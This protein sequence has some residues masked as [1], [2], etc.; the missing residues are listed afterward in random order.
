MDIMNKKTAYHPHPAF[1]RLMVV[2][3]LVGA[4]GLVAV[5]RADEQ[6]PMDLPPPLDTAMPVPNPR[7]AVTPLAIAPSV[8]DEMVVALPRP[9]V[10]RFI[11][12]G[13][14]DFAS[15]K[16]ELSDA[17]K[18]AL[19]KVSDYLSANPGTERLLLDGHTD[20][21]G[22]TRYNN[23]LSDKRAMAV[24]AYLVAKGVDSKLIHWKGHGE[25]LPIDENW[26]RLGRDR[27][28]QVELY[29]VYLPSG[30]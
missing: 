11:S 1:R 6:P 12:L 10:M 20:W 22:G 13:R 5:V 27:N 26:T 23:M 3:T 24:Q 7:V 21:V 17:A 25:H 29:A 30:S 2:L 28:R 14:V 9:K 19:D 15:G 18:Q 4:V 16:W 8:A